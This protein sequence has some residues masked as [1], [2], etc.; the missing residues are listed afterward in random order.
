M[1]DGPDLGATLTSAAAA[2]LFGVSLSTLGKMRR[3]EFFMRGV[4]YQLR[5]GSDE[6][7]PRYI[8]FERACRHL[9]DN[10]GDRP[11]HTR[12]IMNVLFAGVPASE[13]RIDH[14]AP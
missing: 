11:A 14:N 1:K 5:V 9:R 7:R 2:E 8:Y 6:S 12:W 4:H 13:D 3:E 10:M